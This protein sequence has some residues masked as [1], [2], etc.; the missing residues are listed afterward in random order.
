MKVR[1]NNF[2]DVLALLVRG[3]DPNLRNASGATPLHYAMTVSFIVFILIM[4]N[5]VTP[6]S[7]Y[8]NKFIVRYTHNLGASNLITSRSVLRQLVDFSLTLYI[9]FITYFVFL[10]YEMGIQ[11][12]IFSVIIT[13]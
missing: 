4:D 6:S 12:S 3:A 5:N 11:Y 7:I 9:P 10:D 1:D 2:E 8:I 13:L